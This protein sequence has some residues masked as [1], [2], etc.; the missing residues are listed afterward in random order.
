MVDVRIGSSA[1]LGVHVVLGGFR[2][3]TEVPVAWKGGCFKAFTVVLKSPWFRKI[4][5]SVRRAGCIERLYVS[6]EI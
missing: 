3:C 1:H 2:F 5:V 4:V 6:P